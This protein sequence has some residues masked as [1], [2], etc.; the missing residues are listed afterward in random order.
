MV[1]PHKWSLIS[2][3]SSVGQG[4]FAGHRPTFYHCAT[5]PTNPRTFYYF[6][7]YFTI[8]VVVIVIILWNVVLA[9]T[10]RSAST[11]TGT[12]TGSRTWAGIWPRNCHMGSAAQ[13]R[14]F[15]FT[16]ITSLYWS[17]QAQPYMFDIAGVRHKHV[18][19]DSFLSLKLPLMGHQCHPT[20][21]TTKP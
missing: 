10:R 19:R 6:V 12:V 17:L 9:N 13:A 16:V 1:N 15:T 5:W 11:W 8:I 20:I 21:H 7:Q 2:C 3:R 14:T 18:M 4:K